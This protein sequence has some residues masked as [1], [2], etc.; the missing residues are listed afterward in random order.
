MLSLPFVLS[1][2]KSKDEYPNC[3]PAASIVFAHHRKRPSLP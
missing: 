2:A 3:L 1:V